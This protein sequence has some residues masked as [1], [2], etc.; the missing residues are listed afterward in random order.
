MNNILTTSMLTT[1]LT[2]KAILKE[3]VS[4]VVGNKKAFCPKLQ[5]TPK[6]TIQPSMSGAGQTVMPV[7]TS[8]ASTSLPPPVSLSTPT[9]TSLVSIPHLV[10]P[11]RGPP[12]AR[13]QAAMSQGA[14]FKANRPATSEVVVQLLD[15]LDEVTEELH[16][17]RAW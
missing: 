17:K 4:S 16:V 10:N 8:V 6:T 3:L 1:D 14:R 2:F 9:V 5:T 11:N 7:V 15:T 12:W 13:H